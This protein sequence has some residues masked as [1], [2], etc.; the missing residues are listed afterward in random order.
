M[1][2][3][4]Y[5]RTLAHYTNP[6]LKDTPAE[7]LDRLLRDPE[8]S[9]ALV[10]DWIESNVVRMT[11]DGY[12]MTPAL[13]TRVC[14]RVSIEALIHQRYG[15]SVRQVRAGCRYERALAGRRLPRAEREQVWDEAVR[16]DLDRQIA[17]GNANL[18]YLPL[19]D[20]AT[21]RPTSL[22][23]PRHGLDRWE[24]MFGRR[25]PVQLPEWA[26]ET[27]GSDRTVACGSH[28]RPTAAWLAEHG[29]D[30]RM[31]AGLDEAELRSMG[32]DPDAARRSLAERPKT[33]ALAR[34][35]GDEGL[36]KALA[37]RTPG[38]TAVQALGRL[39]LDETW[40]RAA[41]ALA[42]AGG[43]AAAWDRARLMAGA[44]GLPGGR[45]GLLE[46]WRRLRLARQAG[47]AALDMRHDMQV[48][49]A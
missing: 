44:S 10:C 30:E 27:V 11:R 12:V 49:T 9:R 46:C 40:A 5:N 17:K 1:G 18:V 4:E 19:H 32:V 7:K 39:G 47:I 37:E 25:G 43:D 26:D 31:L 16:A 33:R 20:G 29:V 35:L 28:F 23:N 24:E 48:V 22:P 14:R 34:T 6:H 45:M 38:L 42:C 36:A 3:A 15:V 13:L 8:T 2:P 41:V 21:L